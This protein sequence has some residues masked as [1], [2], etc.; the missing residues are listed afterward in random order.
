M[1]FLEGIRGCLT[2]EMNSQ[3][4]QDFHSEEVKVALDQMF[5]TKSPGPNGMLPIF[6][7]KY[8]HIVGEEVTRAVLTVLKT[9]T[10]P[11]S[12]NHTFIVLIPKKKKPEKI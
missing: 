8:W 9:I 4:L 1:D 10:F 6:Y 12:L 2:V 7:Q 11:S 5:P 3:L